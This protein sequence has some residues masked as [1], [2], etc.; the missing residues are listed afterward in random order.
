[1]RKS[2]QV[3]V[4]ILCL[5]Y[6]H[7]PYIERTLNSFLNQKVNF[8]YEILIHDDASTDGTQDIIKKY[9]DKYSELFIPVFQKE[10]KYQNGINVL[11]NYIIPLVRGKYI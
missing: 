9:I 1:M 11:S 10:N 6:N 7:A 3:D 2:D 5:T 4:S 8:K